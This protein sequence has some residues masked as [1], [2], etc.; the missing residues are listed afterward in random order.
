MKPILEEQLVNG[1]MNRSRT[2]CIFNV[3]HVNYQNKEDALSSERMHVLP[4]PRWLWGCLSFLPDRGEE[5][6]FNMGRSRR[7]A[8]N[9]SVGTLWT[10]GGGGGLL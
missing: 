9:S 10:T 1:G 8:H 4:S 3:A 2:R 6:G 5:M 7:K